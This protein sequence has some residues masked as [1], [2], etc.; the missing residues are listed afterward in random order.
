MR[1]ASA[2]CVAAGPGLSRRL[3]SG[4]SSSHRSAGPSEA[5]VR[6]TAF[7]ARPSL[8]LGTPCPLEMPTCASPSALAAGVILW[9]LIG[10]VVFPMMAHAA[11]L[12]SESLEA[13][14]RIAI[15][16]QGRH[17]P[18]DSF[19]RETLDFITGSPRIGRED[20]V[21]TVLSIISDPERWQAE[22]LIAVPFRPLREALEMSP[23]ASHVSYNE[24]IATRKLMRMLP[25]IVQKQQRDE[26]LSMLEQE[27]MD[28]YERFV[29]LNALFE[30]DLE[31]VPPPSGGPATSWLPIFEPHGYPPNQYAEFRVRWTALTSAFREGNGQALQAA[32]GELGSSLR[33]ANPAAYLAP[34]RLTL[35]VFYNQ[36]TPFRIARWL[37]WLAALALLVSFSGAAA[38]LSGIGMIA[39]WIAFA[40]HGAGIITRVVLG[41]RPPVSNFYE[42]MLWLPFVAVLLAIIFEQIYKVKYFG[43]AASILAAITLILADHLPLDPSISPVVAV[44]R[45]NLWLTIHVLTIVASYGALTLATMLAHIYGVQILSRRRENT[46]ASLETFLYRAIQV[47]VVLLAAGIML[48]AV[49]ANASWGRYWGWDPKETWALITLL[50]FLAMLHGRFAGW[51]KGP[52]LALG[53]IAGFFLLLMT[54]YGVSF[55]LVGLHSYA[56]GHAKPIPSLLIAYLIAEAAFMV[57]VGLATLPGSSRRHTSL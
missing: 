46:L 40:V 47:G 27:T 38:R 42:T 13:V 43:I 4:S 31:L 37:Y 23:K 1:H 14:R 8:S 18:F 33:S 29:T 9:L 52:G 17:K 24:L 10:V 19:A 44:L 16:H 56:G 20:P 54:Y 45:S 51:L 5:S 22:R 3:C 11:S 55:Y 12:S 25:A 48:G 26:K 34:W 41:G 57:F 39:L 7:L 2:G 36:V 50:W 21:V 53:T 6:S 32:A 35:E 30:Q 28:V 49:W 15:Q